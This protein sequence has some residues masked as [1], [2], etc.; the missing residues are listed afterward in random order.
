MKPTETIEDFYRHKFNWMPDNLRN[1]M[2]HFNVFGMDEFA[3]KHPGPVPYSRKDFFKISLNI[4]KFRLSYA[5]KVVEIQDHALVFSNPMIPYKWEPLTEEKQSGYFCIF[6]ESF[7]SQFGA[8][9]EYPVFQPG[10]QPVYCLTR[11]QVAPIENIFRRMREE[12]RSDYAYKYDVLRNR[13]YELIHF[14]L[15]MQ[16]AASAPY[17]DSNASTRITSLFME[18]LERQFPIESQ[19]QRLSLRSAKDYADRL[20]VHVNHLNKVLK[21]GTG[22]T[23]TEIISKRV[24]QEAKILLKQT[25]WNVS[26][27]SWSLG[28]DDIAHF[29]NFFKKHTSFTPLGYRS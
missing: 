9:K 25:D 8:I 6:T 24:I 11:D 23:T 1:G 22:Q 26:E 3:G 28:Y 2:G 12:I 18:L 10:G 4:G 15:R 19:E 21:E 13:T 16:P 29:S 17:S 5:D 7:F 20:A 27:I 14:A